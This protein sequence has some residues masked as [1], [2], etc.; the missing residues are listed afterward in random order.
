MSLKF[1]MSHTIQ[2]CRI[3]GS[4]TLTEVLSLGEQSLTGVFPRSTE[5]KI[6][7]GSL[8]LVKCEGE[9]SCGLI[10]LGQSFDAAEM[11]GDNYG[12]RSGLNQSMVKHLDTKVARLQ[13]Y[14]GGLKTG[15]LVLDIGCND[16]TLLGFYPET[17]DRIGIDPTVGKFLRFY[18]SDIEIIEGFFSAEIYKKHHGSRKAKIVTS[19]A[20][21][22]DLESPMGF[23]EQ[24]ASIL[25]DDGVWHFEQSYLPAML[26]A[27]AYDTICH[28]HLE[29]YGLYQIKWMLKRCGLEIVDF[30][31]SDVNGGSF[32]VTAAKCGAPYKINS[33]M[34]KGVLEAE[35]N[36]CLHSTQPYEQFC[37]R[38]LQHRDELMN[39]LNALQ[40]Q[41]AKIFGYGASTKGNVILQFCGITAEQ[42]PYIADV[43]PDKFGCFTP[44]TNI[45][46]I[47]EEEAHSMSPDYF[48]VLPWHFRNNIIQRET[49]FLA[50]G[51]KLLFPL[52]QIEIVT[53]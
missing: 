53:K 44:G 19:I 42:I 1:H 30:E 35:K 17:V 32:A 52:P 38:I 36:M 4:Q 45:P 29:Y 47:S 10:Q 43:N 24:I 34:I 23:V 13:E 25:A 2:K 15:E 49:V 37:A 20:M 18:N 27:N 7:R 46:I 14:I 3:C 8:E 26:N 31:L 39:K 40:Q 22:Y 11:Y 21:F 50:N 16:G 28:E 12:Y 33:V 6:S 48:L 51:G 41:G 9:N 5:E